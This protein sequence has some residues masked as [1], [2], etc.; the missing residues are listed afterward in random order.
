MPATAST[1]PPPAA[2]SSV[3]SCA[4]SGPAAA[5][6]HARAAAGS[7]VSMDRVSSATTGTRIAALQSSPSASGCCPENP[8]ASSMP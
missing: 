7:A 3:E 1:R 2:A 5:A 6:T 8:T 4:R